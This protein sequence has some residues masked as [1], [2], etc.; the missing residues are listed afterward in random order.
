YGARVYFRHVSSARGLEAIRRGRARGQE[1][2][3]ETGPHYLTLDASAYGRPDGHYFIVHPP[4]RTAADQEAL[5]RGVREG[6]VNCLGTDHCALDTSQKNAGH[7]FAHV[8]GGLPGVDV[9]LPLMYSQGVAAGRIDTG[10]LAQVSSTGAAR[11]F[12]LYPRKGTLQPGADA[13][14]VL[15]DPGLKRVVDP[16]QLPTALD[17]SPYEGWEL[18]GWPRGVVSRGEVIVWEDQFVGHAGRGRYLGV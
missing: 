6:A 3:A 13:D 15:L 18:R 9:L 16:A 4:L 17:W 1:V 12:G 14:L 11:A 2:W 7:D 5:W 10:R 8:P